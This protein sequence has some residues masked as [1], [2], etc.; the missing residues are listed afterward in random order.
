VVNKP[1][2]IGTQAETAV[3]SWLQANGHEHAERRTL[4]G[5]HDKGDVSGIPGIC[6]EVKVAGRRGL[7]LGPWLR[8]TERER[9]NA[10]AVY[11][12]LVAKPTGLGPKRTGRWLAAMYK[13]DWAMLMREG[14][15]PATV[16]PED[17][18]VSG[19]KVNQL[20]TILANGWSDEFQIPYL[21]R[22]V[23]M[24]GEPDG[25]Y[26]VGTLGYFNRLLLMAGYGELPESE[27]VYGEA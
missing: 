16:F 26:V 9:V 17:H 15:W 23:K 20:P 4:S 25:W 21:V 6:I 3:V 11:G 12:I 14:G 22:A 19:T 10:N 18:I 13:G 7:L 8:E 24:A 1:K 5:I 27:A 2:I